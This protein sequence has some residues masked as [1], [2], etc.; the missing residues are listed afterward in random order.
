MLGIRE[1]PSRCVQCVDFFTVRN[2]S[3]VIANHAVLFDELGSACS[4]VAVQYL[5]YIHNLTSGAAR[6]DVLHGDA[7]AAPESEELQSYI[8]LWIDSMESD[9]K[10]A[11]RR[12][13]QEALEWPR[14]HGEK[15]LHM[16][17]TTS[18]EMELGPDFDKPDDLIAHLDVAMGNS[19]AKSA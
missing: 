7:P 6:S 12:T 8:R 17:S 2:S 9:P 11:M 10:G 18:V 3:A 1:R 13:I 4:N 5:V 16:T 14:E 15:I 19:M